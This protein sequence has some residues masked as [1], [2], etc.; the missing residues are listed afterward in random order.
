MKAYHLGYLANH[1]YLSKS[2][3]S[4]EIERN[5]RIGRAVQKKPQTNK[6]LKGH[7]KSNKK[8]KQRLVVFRVKGVNFVKDF[9]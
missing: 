9:K 4:E 3:F 5:E 7:I 6:K 1:P 8:C 2:V